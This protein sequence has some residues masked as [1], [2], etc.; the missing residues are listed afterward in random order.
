MSN[1][2]G[3]NR[4]LFARERPLTSR[5]RSL[6]SRLDLLSR[7]YAAAVDQRDPIRFAASFERPE[8][9]EVAGWIASAFAYLGVLCVERSGSW[10]RSAVGETRMNWRIIPRN[11]HHDA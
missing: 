7:S 8:D 5:E 6:A 1:F 3:Q 10:Q 9:R 2:G 11:A 4:A